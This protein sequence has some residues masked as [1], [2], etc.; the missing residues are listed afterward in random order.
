MVQPGVVLTLSLISSAVLCQASSFIHEDILAYPRYKVELAEKKISE[1]SVFGQQQPKPKQIGWWNTQDRQG[2][3][4]SQV[5]MMTANSQPFLCTIPDITA[6]Q[7][8]H[9]SSSTNTKP[10][11]SSSLKETQHTIERGLELLKPLTKNCLY[12]H[13]FGYWTYEYCHMQ[14]VRQFH[15]DTTKSDTDD[16][17]I[18]DEKSSFILGSFPKQDDTS[19]TVDN[20]NDE[21]G[22]VNPQAKH[23]TGS[24][25]D[26]VAIHQADTTTATSSSS[27]STS[28]TLRRVDGQHLLVQH[29]GN[30]SPCDITNQ[31][32]AIDVQFQ[33]GPENDRIAFIE[34]VS[35]CRYRMTIS[36][37]RLCDDSM[38]GIK[39]ES[40]SHPIE[41]N[42]IVPEHWISDHEEQQND[43]SPTTAATEA[44]ATE[45][46]TLETIEQQDSVKPTQHLSQVDGKPSKEETSAPLDDMEKNELVGMISSLSR[47]VEQLQ[48]SMEQQYSIDQLL[49][50]NQVFFLDQNGQMVLG[51]GASYHDPLQ[52]SSVT[53]KEAVTPQTLIKQF[54][55]GTSS[56]P[57][58]NS[59][60][61]KQQIDGAE[62]QKQNKEAYK[63]NY[64]SL[65]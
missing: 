29:W 45:A 25:I 16:K 28:A 40:E 9:S 12:F 26:K 64:Y 33:C 30:G 57:T 6:Q 65:A 7:K 27:S 13:S 43:E 47:Q 21:E 49:Q 22:T 32:R 5:I 42:P 23:S 48:R 8:H 31:P 3:D 51:P 61:H 17:L 1:S 56:T 58:D 53:N 34:E 10:D 20:R 50:Q 19:S 39:K 63:K 36:T 54:L 55:L 24:N 62:S 41:C 2:S 46:T 14:H 11:P 60:R 38:L 52:Q 37:P 18:L 15:V 35:T 59:N 44:A 4:Y